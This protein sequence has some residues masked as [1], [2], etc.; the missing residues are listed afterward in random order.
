MKPENMKSVTRTRTSPDQQGD[1]NLA[2]D[3]MANGSSQGHIKNR[4]AGNQH[5]GAAEGNFGR[6][7]TVGN[8]GTSSEGPKKPPTSAVPDFK[9]ASKRAFAGEF[10]AGAQ[11]RTPGGTRRFDPSATQNYSG[12]IDRINEGRGPTKGNQQ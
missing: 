2:S 6:G 12:N 7:P 4:F 11:D 5:G 9:A 3:G 8:N 1:R 10:N